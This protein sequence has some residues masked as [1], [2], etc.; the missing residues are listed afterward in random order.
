MPGPAPDRAP[1][2][3]AAGTPEPLRSRLVA[4][5]GAD[6]VLTRALDLIRYASDASPYRLIPQAVAVPRDVKDM[7]A[8]LRCA[9]ELGVPV[10]FRAGGTSLNGQSQTDAIL[11]DVR[12]HWRR[13][14]V[15]DDG[16]RLRAQPG[17]VLGHANRLLARR[18]RRLGPDPASTNIA[19]VGGVIANNSGGM[20]CGVIADSYRTVSAMTLVLA[21]GAVINT[22]DTDAEQ[23]FATAAPELAAGLERIRDGIRSDGELSQRIARKFQIKNTTGYRLCAFLDADTPLEIFRRLVVGSEGTLAFVAEAVFDTVP[24]GRHTTLALASFDDLD[25]AA[26]AVGELVD[27]G[28]TATELMVAPT[29]IAAAYNMAGIPEAWKELPPTS[30]ALLIEFRAETPEELGPLEAAAGAILRAHGGRDPVGDSAARFSRTAEDLEMLWRV[31]EGMQGLLAAVRPPGITMMIEDV[32]VPPARVAEAA[33]DLQALLLGHGFLPGLAGHASAGNLHFILTAEFGKEGELE[34]YDAF[35]SDLV[36]LIVDKYDG[37]L[38]AEH[39]TGINMAPFVQR[40]WGPEATELMWEIKRLADPAG[41]LA[42]GVVLNRDPGVH[43]RNLKSVPE[44]EESVTKCIECGFCEPVCP[45][46]NV[47]TTPRQRIVL[48]REMARQPPGSPVRVALSEQ[49][50]YDGIETCAADGSCMI[51]CPVGIDTGTLIKDLRGR[52]HSPRA[53]RVALEVARRYAMAERVARAGLPIAR[54]VAEA[55]GRSMPPPAPA[56]LPRT[57]RQGAVA[58]YLPSCLNRIFGRPDGTGS[59]P[60]HPARVSLPEALVAISARAQRPLWIPPDVAGHCCGTPWSSKG[61]AD[62]LAEMAARTTAALRR[63]TDGGELPVV[64]DASSCTLGLRENLALDGIEVIDSVSWVHDHLIER[65]Q[66]T[67]RLGSVVIHPTCAT[68][69]LHV[70]GKL[71]AVAG[72][73]AD[74]VVVPAATRCC[75][76]AGDRGWLYPELP[77][78]ALADTAAELEGRTFDACLSSNRTCEIA[79]QQVTGRP[80]ESLVLTLEALTRS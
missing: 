63:W 39:G 20:R 10:T 53:Q 73:L 7:G 56:K 4:A 32:C 50:E 51:A 35:I 80:Y 62:G 44:V 49:Y 16:A 37:S 40:E 41:I 78:A 59:S 55:R 65:L 69:H 38:K 26:G 15:E 27:A 3:V 23:Q 31:R 11:V 43:L 9:T 79:L 8:L 57:Q 22:A 25:A 67:H 47:T 36:D 18:S 13:V 2:W 48:R 1:D 52:D 68:G 34:R 58:V 6:R 76:M 75:G 70:S 66:V 72:R 17:V 77:A 29:L 12:R 19:C 46:Q 21:N 54:R 33:K 45:S 30:A 74:E 64:M 71:A 5:L 61:Y 60:I 14:R 28:A 42:L 24:L